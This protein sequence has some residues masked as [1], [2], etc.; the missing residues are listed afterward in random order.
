MSSEEIIQKQ[1]DAYNNRVGNNTKKMKIRSLIILCSL[2]YSLTAC[3]NSAKKV[4]DYN[5]Y[6]SEIILAEELIS[7]EKY[8]EA[9]IRYEKLFNEYDFIFLRDYKIAS[10]IS[11]LIGEKEKGLIYVKKAISNGWELIHLKEQK[12]LSKNLLDS[13]WDTI[14]KQYE[15]LR[16]QFLNKI[17]STLKNRVHSMF[18]KDQKIAYEAYI[19]EDEQGQEQFITENFPKHSEEQLVN[20][21]EIIEING[22]PG[23]LLIGNDF[24][25]STILSHHNSQGTQYVKKDT[26][27]DFIKPKLIQFL[28]EGYIS[29]YE[30][31]LAEDWKKAV[32]S[33]WNES[34]YGYL[35]PP[36]TSTISQINKT[37]KAIG[38]RTVALRNKLIDI[39]AKTGMNFYLPDW[40]DGKIKIEEK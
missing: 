36:N 33:E 8:E 15:E 16:N 40:V 37:R 25:V 18:E 23:E 30:I 22:Y 35:N 12:F 2:L 38:L 34:S 24:W 11:F 21:L 14:E 10:Q 13:D 1:L 31:A 6:H 9:L 28:N 19:I 17:D 3:E 5:K 26:L 4:I 32:T 7:Q 20:L 39:E 27:Y 29:P